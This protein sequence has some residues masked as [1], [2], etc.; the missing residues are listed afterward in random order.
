M[1]WRP[2]ILSLAL[3]GAVL[4]NVVL[5]A[6]ERLPSTQEGPQVEDVEEVLKH[7][8]Y[9]PTSRRS[10]LIAMGMSEDLAEA[11]ATQI[12]RYKRLEP[13][14]NELL[15]EQASDV[16]RAF[17]PSSGLPQPYAAMKFLVTGEDANRDVVDVQRLKLFEAQ[18]WYDLTPVSPVYNKFELTS[19]RRKDATLMGVSALLIGKEEDALDGQS[20][21]STGL[22][23]SWGWAPLRKTYPASEI[24]VIQYFSLMH[25]LTE[26]ANVRNG[27]CG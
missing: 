19:G 26:L 6:Q 2:W 14:F 27:I 4:F 21:W 10:N 23:G 18:P 11:T 3:L 12:D 9:A 13:L 17:C 15:T 5:M 24:L 25:Y 8:Q 22:V 16:G 1:R 20:P 7:L